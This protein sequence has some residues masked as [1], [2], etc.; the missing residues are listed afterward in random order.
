MSWNKSYPQPLQLLSSRHQTHLCLQRLLSRALQQRPPLWNVCSDCWLQNHFSVLPRMLSSLWS[1]PLFSFTSHR[2][3]L[4]TQLPWEKPFKSCSS[5]PQTILKLS[6]HSS[7]GFQLLCWQLTRLCGCVFP[8]LSSTLNRNIH[9]R[10][11]WK[12]AVSNSSLPSFS[13]VPICS[14]LCLLDLSRPPKCPT[15]DSSPFPPCPHPLLSSTHNSH[16]V[17]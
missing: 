15:A 5:L 9:F 16:S 14:L 10:S 11:L 2:W 6:F 12:A 7:L 17:S 13:A 4:L 3:Q 8:V 1:V